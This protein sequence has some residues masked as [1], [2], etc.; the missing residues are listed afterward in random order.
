MEE[1]FLSSMQTVAKPLSS[2]SAC[3][4]ACIVASH[5]LDCGYHSSP[6]QL[7]ALFSAFHSLANDSRASRFS[8]TTNATGSVCTRGNTCQL[9]M[10]SS[11]YPPMTRFFPFRFVFFWR[12][13]PTEADGGGGREAGSLDD[14]LAASC[15]EQV[16]GYVERASSI[17]CRD[18]NME[19]RLNGGFK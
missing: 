9:G 3:A 18:S 19:L 12:T 6:H 7:Q 1:N 2:S 8:S 11:K 4:R 14:M 17:W 13:S 15:D 16:Y 5:L 10:S